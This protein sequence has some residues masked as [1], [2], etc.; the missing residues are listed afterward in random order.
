M[1]KLAEQAWAALQELDDREQDRLANMILEDIESERKWDELLAT[2][3]SQK[4]LEEMGRKA[5]EDYHAGRTEPLCPED[6]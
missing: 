5:M 3:E 6:L 4:W 2:P 1:T